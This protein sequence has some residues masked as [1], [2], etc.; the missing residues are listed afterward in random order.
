MSGPIELAN[1]PP[2]STRTSLMADLAPRLELTVSH[3]HLFRGIRLRAPLAEVTCPLTASIVDLM[4]SDGVELEA[5]LVVQG[6][7]ALTLAVPA[8]ETATGHHVA[9]AMWP[10]SDVIT[11]DDTVMIKL[12]LRLP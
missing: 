1:R 9:A 5:E 12:G 10:I 8:Y 4:F 2:A 3:S 7:T 6:D 11:D